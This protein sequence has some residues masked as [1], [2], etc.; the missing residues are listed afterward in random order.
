MVTSLLH[1]FS[2]RAAGES[3]ERCE[4]LE[5]LVFYY[6]IVSRQADL[7]PHSQPDTVKNQIENHYQDRISSLFLLP[8][9]TFSRRSCLTSL[10][11][12]TLLSGE[13]CEEGDQDPDVTALSSAGDWS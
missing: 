12:W 4:E 8:T 6:F 3:R 10:H 1:L 2:Y 13:M 7:F 9:P 11:I 5:V